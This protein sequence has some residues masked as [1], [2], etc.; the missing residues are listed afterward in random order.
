MGRGQYTVKDCRLQLHQFRCMSPRPSSQYQE[1]ETSGGDRNV[2]SVC[3]SGYSMHVQ[4][5][6]I[7][8]ER[9]RTGKP[10]SR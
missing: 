1:T 10:E 4:K 3:L 2:A 6:I 9:T 5:R 8:L 7:E